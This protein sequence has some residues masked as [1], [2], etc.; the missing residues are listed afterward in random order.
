MSGKTASEHWSLS[1]NT[2][3]PK[4]RR[5]RRLHQYNADKPEWCPA[6]RASHEGDR[7]LVDRFCTLFLGSLAA[8]AAL[9]A[10]PAAAQDY[11]A[12]KTA[13]QLF[14]SDCTGCHKTSAGLSKGLDARA[15]TGFLREHYT[16]RTESAAALAAYLAGGAGGS[17]DA[18]QKGQAAPAD[19]GTGPKPPRSVARPG[20]GEPKPRVSA[21]PATAPA[22]EN[23]G[24]TRTARPSLPP[25]EGVKPREGIRPPHDGAKADEATVRKLESYAAAGGEAKDS[26]P[27]SM[28]TLDS[29]ANAGSPAAAIAAEGA[30]TTKPKPPEKKKKNSSSTTPSTASAPSPSAA[31]AAPGSHAA[32]QRRPAAAGTERHTGNN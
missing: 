25:H 27:E 6:R 29:Y 28:K 18:K 12:G 4:C 15:L 3:S 17:A 11:S 20:E 31:P 1:I 2:L 21:E 32:P 10:I 24:G 9:H 14:Q 16:T 8:M 19:P 7:L 23:E 30:T 13:A 5:P 26:K 22:E